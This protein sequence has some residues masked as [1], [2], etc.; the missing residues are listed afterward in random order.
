VRF[1]LDED[2]NPQVAVVLRRLGVWAA[3]TQEAGTRGADDEAQLAYAAEVRAALVTRN[4]NDFIALTA[5][6]F[7]EDREHAGVV[8]VPHSVPADNPAILS[9]LLARLAADYPHGLPQ[10]AVIFLK[11]YSR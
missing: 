4:R 3:S 5:Q 7:D 11:A 6:F 2:I 1:Y 10:Y 8:I 9:K